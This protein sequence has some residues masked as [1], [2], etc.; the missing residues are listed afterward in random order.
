MD[1]EDGPATKRDIRESEERLEGRFEA[2]MTIMEDRLL[3]R[4]RD[5][6]T[7]LL[8]VFL[9]YAE[10]SSLRDSALEA[11]QAALEARSGSVERRLFEIEKKLL[12][13]PPAA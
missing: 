9:P 5:M 12:M 1:P 8:K 7:E 3:E 11:R 2:R 4:M 6:Q 13:D 10:H